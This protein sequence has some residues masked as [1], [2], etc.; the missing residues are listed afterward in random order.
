MNAVA[1]QNA[2]CSVCK[3]DLTP[4][5]L[6]ECKTE[7]PKPLIKLDLGC[8]PNKRAGFTGVDSREFPGVDQVVDLAQHRTLTA[9]AAAERDAFR[10]GKIAGEPAYD[11]TETGFV[12]WPW[13]DASVEEIHASHILEHFTAPQRMHIFNEMYRVLIPNGKATI[14]T[15]WWASGRAYGDPTHQWPPVCEMSYYYL[16]REWRAK[17]APH[18]DIEYNPA[19]YTCDFDHSGGYTWHP[20]VAVRNA[21]YQMY[22]AKFLKEAAQDLIVTVIRRP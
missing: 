14:I 15:P 21:E 18:T 8:G 22:A 6:C 1:D 20:E 17:N 11:W 7:S 12:P 3:Q 13:L 16:N 9:E 19:G 5:N 10:R 4:V 2:F